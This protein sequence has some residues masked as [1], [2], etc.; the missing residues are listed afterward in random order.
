M[1]ADLHIHIVTD[2]ITE[3][4][5]ADF[6]SSTLG[7]KWFNP[8][9][10]NWDEREPIFGVVADS[11]SVWVGAVSW[12]KAAL[13]EDVEAYVPNPI[14]LVSEIVGE[15][16]PVIDDELIEKIKDALQV[17]N[18]TAYR[19]CNPD[20]VVAFLEEHSGKRCFTVSW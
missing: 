3:D 5:L 14:G 2:A 6:F 17:N 15:E 18:Q 1:A 12:L 11:P 19:F 8:T 7:S 13:F 20:D 10:K 16:L 4:V 9:P